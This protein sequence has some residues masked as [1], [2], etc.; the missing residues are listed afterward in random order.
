V[1]I[2]HYDYSVAFTERYADWMERGSKSGYRPFL[3]MSSTSPVTAGFVAL[4]LSVRPDLGPADVKRLLV[5]SSRPTVFEG[6]ESP[7]TVD[8]GAAVRAATGG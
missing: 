8:I 6:N 1:N 5:E 7:R 2:L 4:L 3:S